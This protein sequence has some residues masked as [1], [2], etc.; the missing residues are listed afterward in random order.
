MGSDKWGIS[1]IIH[2]MANNLKDLRRR[3]GWTQTEA[4]LA[5]GLSKGGYVKIEDG[6]RKLSESYI[7]KAAEV[8]GVS[9]AEVIGQRTTV[10]V[11]GFVGA[12]AEAH[13]YADGQGPFDEAPAPVDA[14]PYTVAVEIRGDSLGS[15]FDRW[16]VYYNDRRSP[17]T[18]DLIGQ[19][20]VVGLRDGRVLVK[21]LKRSATRGL[22]HLYGQFGDPILDVAVEWAAPVTHI[23]PNMTAGRDG[24]GDSSES[25]AVVR[26]SAA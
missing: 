14:T 2:T 11:V 17:V 25:R 12:G 1:P 20:C 18:A 5:F 16:M 24:G 15:F 23:V 8:Y 7:R 10:P 13:V 22:F 6:D 19:L 3:R 26:A 21:K 9:E 4:A